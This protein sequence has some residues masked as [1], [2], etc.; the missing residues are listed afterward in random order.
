MKTENLFTFENADDFKN[1]LVAGLKYPFVS[2]SISTLGGRENMSLLLT[3]STSTKEHWGFGIL[4]NSQYAKISISNNGKVECFS[5][6]LK[7]RG[8]TSCKIE[9]VL[10]NLNKYGA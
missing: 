7:V 4:E 8:F 1:K 10:K 3:V 6:S 2:C 9:T 5:G